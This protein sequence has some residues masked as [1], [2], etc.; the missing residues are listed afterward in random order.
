MAARVVLCLL[1]LAWPCR[2]QYEP[3]EEAEEEQALPDTMHIGGLFGPDEWQD[4][5][6]FRSAI[7]R[8]NMDKRVL[9]HV[10]LVPVVEV[11]NPVDGFAV[12]RKVCGMVANGVSALFGPSHRDL[13]NIVSSISETLEIPHILTHYTSL[14]RPTKLRVNV[15]PDRQSISQAIVALL[16]DMAWKSFTIIYEDDEAL[17]RLQEVLKAHGPADA[18]ITVRRL[19]DDP[20][21]RP[22]LK[23]IRNSTETRIVLD[24]AP[25]KIME[26]FRQARQVKMMGDYIS[27]LVTSLDAHTA[28]F[29]EFG[30]WKQEL[31]FVSNVTGLRLL[32]P[33]G[34]EVQNALQDWLY[35]ERLR[36][37]TISLAAAEIKTSA[38]L[39]NDAVH[40]FA[41]SLHQLNQ[42][43]PPV[44]ERQL[45]C[46][47]A[48]IWEHGERIVTF[49]KSVYGNPDTDEVGMTGPLSLDADADFRRTNFSLTLIDTVANVG[50][51][52]WNM[53]GIHLFRSVEEMERDTKEQLSKRTLRVVSKLGPPF[54]MMKNKD[55]YTAGCGNECLR[56]Y[57]VDLVEA[58]S[59]IL[60][61]KYEF[62]V[63]AD[64]QYG[65]LKNG[66]WNG[67]I[68]DLLDRKADLGLCDLTITYDRERAVDFTMPFM[69]LGI[70]ILHTI[71][72]AP[73]TNR[74]SFLLPLSTE[75]WIYMAFAYVAVSFLLFVLARVTPGEWE[76]TTP[77]EEQTSETILE[78][79]LN[80]SNA[81]WHNV[82]SLMQQGS[83][84]APKAASTR[85]VAGMWWFFV[86]I[87]ISSYTAN[88]AAFLTDNLGSDLIK[89][90][91]DLATQ[92]KVQYGCV[93]GG[94]TQSF[95]A[96]SNFSD[97]QRMWD[98]MQNARPSVFPANNMEGVERVTKGKGQYAFLMESTSIEYQSARICNLRQVGGLLDSKG[99]GIAMPRNS[100]FR[101]V[102]SGAVLRLQ[103]S[104]KLSQLKDL[105]W[106]QYDD[107]SRCAS[108]AAPASS[109]DSNKL[110]LANVGGV[111]LVLIY[112]CA[113][114]FVMAI[115]EFLWN[116]RSVAIENRISVSDAFWKELKF[117]INFSVSTKPV[118]HKTPTPSTA[119][120]RSVRSSRSGSA[121]PSMARS[122]R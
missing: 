1:L 66:A 32:D 60:N 19:G 64:G 23:E 33:D 84:I 107:G 49:M 35:S 43:E 82:G 81:I 73:E 25:D 88:L 11:L 8:V 92:T 51:G 47:V 95:F 74:F 116:S 71:P 21:Y 90:A 31:P 100:P 108:E 39:I 57:S 89:D 62:Y 67:L 48:Q 30:E 112:G 4:I 12:S 56:G 3:P 7:E 69:T 98:Y 93:Y 6:A 65:S 101:G 24:V 37:N 52:V 14:R 85:M 26:I 58:I 9:P 28:D 94:S 50:T 5:L 77:S 70:S 61:F 118:K 63:V 86:L 10:K 20:D 34:G 91:K 102:I 111:F 72:E 105:W 109:V 54:L 15:A 38:A 55:N 59:Q 16:E 83:D 120:S 36:G 80:L 44:F 103:E 22:L 78:Y 40:M 97:Y 104:G 106:R 2:G 13:I 42:T 119:A 114:A 75:V 53:S 99:Y 113:A 110:G 46:D 29:G 96:N 41:R 79:T 117:A 27:Y 121:T 17:F 87:M 18:P 122:A 76:S 45:S 68:K 115:I